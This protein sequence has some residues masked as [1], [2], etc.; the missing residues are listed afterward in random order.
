LK[1]WSSSCLRVCPTSENS[2]SETVRKAPDVKEWEQNTPEGVP[3]LLV[4]S[5]APKEANREMGLSSTVV[6]D[7][8]FAVGQSFG[9]LARRLPGVHPG[10]ESRV[11]HRQ[12][13]LR[14]PAPR[15]VQRPQRLLRGVRPPRHRPRDRFSRFLPPERGC[16]PSRRPTRCWR[17]SRRSTAATSGT[18]GQRASWQKSTSS[19]TRC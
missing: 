10:F 5:T 11:R 9:A 12:E 18:R 7:Q 4:V 19:R 8:Q 15:L 14:G 2:T 17:E 13:R 1:A 3:N 6:L 16:S